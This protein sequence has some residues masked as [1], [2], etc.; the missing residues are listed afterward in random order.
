MILIIALLRLELELYLTLCASRTPSWPE[1]EF[2]S[3]FSILVLVHFA[4]KI[5]NFCLFAVRTERL[6]FSDFRLIGPFV[7]SCR[8]YVK[9]FECGSLN[10]PDPNARTKHSQGNLLNLV[11]EM[12]FV[13][14]TGMET[15]EIFCDMDFDYVNLRRVEGKI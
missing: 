2:L 9:Q 1:R 12:C 5:D 4:L 8:A 10:P 6:A 13:S 14:I 15:N 3:S 7:D 11:E